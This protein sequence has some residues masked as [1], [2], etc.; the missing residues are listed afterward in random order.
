MFGQLVDENPQTPAVGGLQ[1]PSRRKSRP[2]PSPTSTLSTAVSSIYTNGSQ[3]SPFPLL[4]PTSS[5][6]PFVST[7]NVSGYYSYA[8]AVSEIKEDSLFSNRNI[9]EP[10]INDNDDDY[11]ILSCLAPPNRE[12][13]YHGFRG[14]ATKFP[15]EAMQ[16]S[17]LAW[18]TSKYQLYPKCNAYH[19]KQSREIGMSSND[20]TTNTTMSASSKKKLMKTEYCKFILNNEPCKFGNTC[21]F[22]H[23]ESEL[24]YKTLYERH[25]AGLLDKET[26]RT[27]PCF[28]FVAT[29]SW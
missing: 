3:G 16:L 6:S 25:D 1:T 10:D 29:G 8:S 21:H 17:S 28:D 22:A 4:T 11:N 9:F 7:Q 18:T 13:T 26:M 5:S 23:S 2:C 12:T 24:Q 14:V 19:D 15:H 27:R 20:P